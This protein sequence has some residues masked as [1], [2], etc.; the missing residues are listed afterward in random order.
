MIQNIVFDM[1]QVLIHW[2]PKRLIAHLG[3]TPR[4]EELVLRELFQSVEWIMLDRG[5]V[6]GEEAAERVCAR[7]PEK[8]H[9]AVREE[10]FRW[11]ERPLEGVEGMADL[12]RELKGKGY[13]I[14]LLSNASLALRSYFPR[15]PGA[16]CFD[17]LLVSSEEKLLKPQHEIYETF[18]ARFS[19]KP[20]TCF[21][22]DDMPANVEGAAQV[23]I[24]G[25][26]FRGDVSRLRQDLRAAGVAVSG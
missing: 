9:D 19:L 24:R 3:L 26:V 20:E 23:G 13:G 15:I 5:T 8:L 18:L 4:E 1:G 10:I 2:Q 22:V 25:T 6:T 16:E 12:L 7:L 21:F 17:G 11:H 14:Y